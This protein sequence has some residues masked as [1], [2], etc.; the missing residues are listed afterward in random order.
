MLT[1]RFTNKNK[2]LANMMSKHILYYP[3]PNSI[4]YAGS[5]GSLIALF[6]ILHIYVEPLYYFFVDYYYKMF[7]VCITTED[8]FFAGLIP[9]GKM[10]EKWQPLV[11]K[12]KEIF[13]EIGVAICVLLFIFL[14]FTMQVLFWGTL[15]VLLGVSVIA[16]YVAFTIFGL[17]WFFVLL[18]ITTIVF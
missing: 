5:F 16:N 11:K 7:T 9:F 17:D 14:Y 10:P 8:L 4:N 3:T 2:I 15:I 13:L 1:L 6:F 18:F 12:L